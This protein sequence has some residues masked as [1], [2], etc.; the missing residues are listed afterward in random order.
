[1]DKHLTVTVKRLLGSPLSIDGK[2]AE[3]F[4]YQ[5]P[6]SEDAARRGSLYTVVQLS[7]RQAESNLSEWG[8]DLWETLR[9]VYYQKVEGS[10]LDALE[11]AV[12]EA[13][14]FLVK[15]V[16]ELPGKMELDFD[17]AAVSLWGQVLY[18]AQLGSVKVYL[19]RDG[20][21]RLIAEGGEEPEI[22]AAS[23]ILKNGDDVFLVTEGAEVGDDKSKTEDDN[24]GE[25][26]LQLTINIEAVPDHEEVVDIEDTA[27]SERGTNL[28]SKLKKKVAVFIK[29]F[30]NR[31]KLLYVEKQPEVMLKPRSSQ[32]TQVIIGF[33]IIALIISTFFTIRRRRTLLRTEAV[34]E[35]LE[36]ADNNLKT[37][38]SLLDLN[39]IKARK[40]L[41]ES[42]QG[43]DEVSGYNI[44]TEELEKARRDLETLFD[45]AANIT[46]TEPSLVYDFA[47]QGSTVSLADVTIN[48]TRNTVYALDKERN[49]IYEVSLDSEPQI[50]RLSGSVTN[51]SLLWATDKLV[52]YLSG[53][54]INSINVDDSSI[55]TGVAELPAD[56]AW[57]DMS[58]YLDN[59][60]ILSTSDSQIYK[61][62]FA[63]SGFS[64]STP[65]LEEDIDLSSAVAL[66][67]DG[68]IF[69]L[70][71]DASLFKFGGGEKV[72][73]GV[74][75]LDKS[76]VQP[77]DLVTTVDSR[78]LY[79]L[80]SGNNRV[81][82]L[83]KEGRYQQ[84]YVWESDLGTCE[85]LLLDE[86]N[87]KLYLRCSNS[88]YTF[89]LNN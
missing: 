34:K 78:Y 13:Q 1:M 71:S 2:W 56:K 67:I 66:T 58:M 15:R 68:N 64:D 87:S 63:N 84:Q 29:S 88:L 12:R 5:P 77:A 65:W 59:L 83:D 22:T 89:G 32:S 55:S 30:L 86:G 60:Y 35:A 14:E 80:D 20:D 69:V 75:N 7:S 51:S 38:E 33:L 79:V 27:E 21:T 41:E 26:V 72:E 8:E 57:A 3:A 16:A 23:G 61:F 31:N 50:G 53:N 54:S 44:K 74:K 70:L 11:E 85:N 10:P 18:L 36:L 52:Y 6:K 25:A 40:L 82:L 43:L 28:V 48:V 76:F 37:A 47:A 39:N 9:G 42:E 62:T 49:R 17:L 73:F 19:R 46:R 81:V 45:K 24:S 4:V